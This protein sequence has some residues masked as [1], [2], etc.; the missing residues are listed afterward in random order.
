M[1]WDNQVLTKVKYS[2]RPMTVAAPEPSPLDRMLREMQALETKLQ[3]LTERLEPVLKPKGIYSPPLDSAKFHLSPLEQ[4]VSTAL[5]TVEK[6]GYQ[7]DKLSERIPK[8][9]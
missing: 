6:L 9:L 1:P 2:H 8:N 3:A 7:L 4:K 5:D